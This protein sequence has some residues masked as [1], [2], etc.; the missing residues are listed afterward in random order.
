MGSFWRHLVQG[1]SIC[2]EI[3]YSLI[4]GQVIFKIVGIGC[5]HFALS[6]DCRLS[7]FI[8]YLG[9]TLKIIFVFRQSILKHTAGNIHSLIFSLFFFKSLFYL[10]EM[11][12]RSFTCSY[13][14]LNHY[15]DKLSSWLRVVWYFIPIPLNKVVS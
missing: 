13:T 1:H 6:F 14:Y 3:L 11:L 15:E 9:F 2:Y 7:K 8:L 5:I 10:L 4:F 12:T